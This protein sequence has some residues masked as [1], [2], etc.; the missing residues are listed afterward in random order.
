VPQN[1]PGE[2]PLFPR[3]IFGQKPPAATPRRAQSRSSDE[4]EPVGHGAPSLYSVA[5]PPFGGSSLAWSPSLA[6]SEAASAMAQLVANSVDRNDLRGGRTRDCCS[7]PPMRE[8][9]QFWLSSLLRCALHR[10]LEEISILHYDARSAFSC[11]PAFI[12]DSLM[13]VNFYILLLLFI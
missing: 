12:G 13:C 9:S 4:L 1:T 2:D 11:L 5:P 6:T 10:L 3:I 8:V 7:L